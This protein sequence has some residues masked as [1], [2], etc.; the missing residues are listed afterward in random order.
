MNALVLGGTRFIGRQLVEELLSAGH[1]V[2]IFNRG[3]SPTVR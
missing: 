1:R 3:R 2:T